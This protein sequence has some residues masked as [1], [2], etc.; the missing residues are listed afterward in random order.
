[1]GITGLLK[2]LAAGDHFR[3]VAGDDVALTQQSTPPRLAIRQISR[4]ITARESP[5][6]IEVL[7][8]INRLFGR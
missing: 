4:R 5:G 6:V 8:V 3:I 7:M 2:T 1:M